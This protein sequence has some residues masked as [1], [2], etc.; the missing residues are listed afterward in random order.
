MPKLLQNRI[1]ESGMLL[2]A[3]ALIA[4]AVW[5]L[6]GLIDRGWWGQLICFA[7]SAYL[8]V[9]L[10]NGNALLR[11]RSRMVSSVFLILSCTFCFNFGSLSAG[12]VQ[13]CS[14]AAIIILFHSYQDDQ[15][16][17]WTFYAFLCL[18]LGSMAFIQLLIFAPIAWLL[19][20]VYLQSLSLRTW[21]ASLI[22]LVT[23]YWFAGVYLLFERDFSPVVGHF[24]QLGL[25]ALPPD[26]STLTMAQ[27]NEI[28]KV[29]LPDM[30]ANDL[31]AAAQMV[32]GTARSMGVTVTE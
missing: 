14:V 26:Y 30:N 28:A 21:V 16:P 20:A 23:P 22:G 12:I 2:P 11:V 32:A 4:L 7:V 13:L 31:E 18:G 25:L 9:E 29:K 6:C 27:V 5:L 19:M 24:E 8:M 15:A 1:A 17:G 3:A 10:S